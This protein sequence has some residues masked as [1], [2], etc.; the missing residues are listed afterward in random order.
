MS[1]FI[2]FSNP[3]QDFSK[4]YQRREMAQ[5]ITSLKG[6]RRDFEPYMPNEG[7]DTHWS[8]DGGNDWWLQFPEDDPTSFTLHYRYKLRADHY[9]FLDWVE[10]RTGMTRDGEHLK[11]SLGTGYIAFLAQVKLKLV[12]KHM[13]VV[14]RMVALRDE[15]GDRNMLVEEFVIIAMQLSKGKANPTEMRAIASQ[16]IGVMRGETGMS[17][18]E[19]VVTVQE[20]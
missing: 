16:E 3:K 12:G 15:P 10:A 7:D 18:D 11:A 1:R 20:P 4:D 8:V 9:A 14:K 6:N 19:V 13:A 5:L 17:A 2:K